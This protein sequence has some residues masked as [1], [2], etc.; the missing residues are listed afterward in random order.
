ME[1][2]AS[3][4]VMGARLLFLSG[5]VVMTFVARADDAASG[6]NKPPTASDLVARA[7]ADM[8]E[9]KLDRARTDAIAALAIDPNNTAALDLRA[10]IYF[11]QKLWSLAERDYTRLNQISPDPAY[12]YKLAQIK[13]L[14]KMYDDARPMFAAL[15]DDPRLGDLARYKVFICDLFGR[16]EAI[17]ARD[18][19][20]LDQTGGKPS[21]YYGRAL[22]LGMHDQNSAAGHYI[23]QATG[24]F[25]DSINALYKEAYANVRPFHPMVAS[26]TTRDGRKFDGAAVFLE[27]D[28]LRASTDSGWVT[29]P[30]D[31]LPEDLS[32]FPE[33]LRVKID[34]R[35]HAV[36]ESVN[37]TPLTFTTRAG[38]TYRQVRWSAQDTGL[39][40]LTPDGWTTIPY[41]ELPDDVSSLPEAA[42]RQI[43]DKRAASAAQA[44]RTSTV[45][46]TTRRGKSYGGV[47]AWL[48][49][50][51]VDVLTDHG[52]VV[53][54]LADLPADL[55]PF[56]L[57]WRTAIT[58]RLRSDAESSKSAVPVSFT[59]QEGKAYVNAHAELGSDGVMILSPN[60]W[61]TVRFI[62]L[63][64]DLSPFPENWR[65]LIR[66]WLLTNVGDTSG[67]RVV[68]FTTRRGKRYDDVRATLDDKGVDVLGP[69]GWV[70]VPF[71]QLPGDLSP[72]PPGWRQAILA[73]R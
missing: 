48:D 45:S 23:A 6:K 18:L 53:V 59:T 56:P 42:R 44:T 17:A 69:N 35:R 68:S 54:P 66:R 51:G 32:P 19:E 57:A 9:G 55:S 28:G 10:S 41:S 38:K 47:R 73:G 11:E 30:L 52:P 12:Q 63:P 26:F 27:A 4:I 8:D 39:T 7:T 43:T 58:A 36:V 46:F 24:K 49:D 1:R 3:G 16:H 64:D 40:I 50:D 33:D 21:Y 62:D 15:K 22:W 61:T 2:S 67:I 65:P 5:A 20:L 29:L 71:D 13:F 72:F 14:Q 31:Q 70:L 34:L 37:A 25:S 60:G